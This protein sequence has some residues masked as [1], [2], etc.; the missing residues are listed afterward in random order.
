MTLNEFLT[1][2]GQLLGLAEKNL[3]AEGQLTQARADLDTAKT[4]IAS[5]S[6][7]NESLKSQLATAQAETT[8]AK[9]EVDAKEKDVEARASRK[10][11]EITASQG[12]PP[13]PATPAASQ[14]A[15]G[16]VD[17]LQAIND[18]VERAEFFQKNKAAIMAA[19]R[20]Q[21]KKV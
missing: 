4:S 1:K 18:P 8:A 19:N 9:A 17:Q 14:Q 5:L 16:I 10:A 12:Q 6:A 3:T 7:E 15:S 20:Q 2:A 11:L 13:A 21:N